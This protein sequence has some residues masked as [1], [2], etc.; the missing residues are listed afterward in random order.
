M[1]V[2]DFVAD[3]PVWLAFAILFAVAELRGNLIYAAGR[4][5]RAGGERTRLA[6]HL[7]SAAMQRAETLVRRVGPIAVTLGHLTVG[8]QSVI[9]AAAGAMR[10]PQRR[11]QIALAAGALLWAA[12]YTT[13]GVAAFDAVTGRIPW[14][15]LAL[16]LVVAAVLVTGVSRLLSRSLRTPSETGAQVP[17]GL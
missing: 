10:M 5:L 13:I 6:R 9:T 2:E 12:I 16:G 7:D 14:W 1:A 3:K 4:G 17:E 15:W 8:I 11:F